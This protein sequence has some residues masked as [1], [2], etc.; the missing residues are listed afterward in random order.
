MIRFASI[1]DV[2]V[3]MQFIDTYWKKGHIMGNDKKFFLY[4]HGM[5]EKIAFVINE[6]DDGSVNAVLGYIPYGEKSRDI[7][8]A[9]WKVEH[10]SDSML[11]IKMLQFLIEKSDARTVSCPGINKRVRVIYE[12]LGYFTGVMKHWYRLGQREKYSIADISSIEIPKVEKTTKY[13]LVRIDNYND[14][15]K[16]Y[17]LDDRKREPDVPFKEKFYIQER[18]YNHPVFT[19]NIYGI[20]NEETI[21]TILITRI[22]ECNGARVIRVIDCIGDFSKLEFIT[23]LL[24]DLL[25]E[26]DAE[27][28]DFYETGLPDDIFTNAGWLDVKNTDNIIPEYFSPYECKNIDIYYFSTVEN[29]ILF[30]GDG[31]QDRPN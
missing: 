4:Q 20:E 21:S 24:D 22:V 2:D 7:M 9:L 31:D 16:C 27:Y 28:I 11:G 14:L 15:E 25:V 18:Y 10:S 17:Q 29:M 5:F 8:L 6:L 30:K 3:I 12:Y 26:Y 13:K 19:Y 23:A 1:T